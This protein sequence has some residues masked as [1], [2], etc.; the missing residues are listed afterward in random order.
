MDRRAFLQASAFAFAIPR[1]ATAQPAARMRRIGMLSAGTLSTSEPAPFY[2][3]LR[4]LGWTEGE[5]LLI[6]RRGAAGKSEAV[7]ALAAG[8][9]RLQPD[10]IWTEGAVA[11]VAAKDATCW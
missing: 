4:E 5:N 10:L 11:S 6:E 8:L 2:A 7:P 1:I 9:V 3:G